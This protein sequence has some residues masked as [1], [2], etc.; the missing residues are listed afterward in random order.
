MK[1]IRDL[2]AKITKLCESIPQWII[3]LAARLVIFR[4]FWLS[5]QTKISGFTLF[6]QDFK[7]WSLEDAVFF[8]FWEYPAPL[9]SN[10]MI[11][12]GTFAEFFLSLAILF[13][14]CT[15][16]AALGLL[17]VTAVIQFVE[18]QGWWTAHVYWALLLLFL[19]REGG[20]RAS[21]DALMFRR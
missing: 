20:G 8:Q 21:L 19:V 17:G 6:G 12:A 14:L 1:F 16:Y 11:Y 10:V 18:P 3:S 9:D 13:G 4:V 7:F 15:R 2:F 5:V